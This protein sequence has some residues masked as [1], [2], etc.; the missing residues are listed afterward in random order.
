MKCGISTACLY[1]MDTLEAL[2]QVAALGPSCAEVFLNTFSELDPAYVNALCRTRE[3][4]GLNVLSVHPF[5][6]E[7]EPFLFFSGYEPRFEDGLRL[8]RRYFEVCRQ[9]GAK[10]LVLHGNRSGRTEIPMERY[11]QRFS[12][13]CQEGEQ[14]GIT[15]AQENVGRC[16]CG[17]PENIRLL[18][19]YATVPV[20]FVLDLKQSRWTG[21]DPLEMAQAMG[22]ENIVHLHLS[23]SDSA[24]DC[25]LPGR[26]QFDFGAFF[27]KLSSGGFSGNAV[28]ELYR[29]GYKDPEELLRAARQ[30]ELLAH[31]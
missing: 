21:T 27:S 8:Y 9:L 24:S 25:I 15:V 29:D 19:Q 4:A 22:P 28:I 17:H 1:P 11:A 31:T 6:S 12:R 18:R 30:L 20:H 23:D 10:L 5:S 13:L 3:A 16:Q 7:M 14:Y 26:G 2:R